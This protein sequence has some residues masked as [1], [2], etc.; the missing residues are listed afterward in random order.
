MNPA[1]RIALVERI[2]RGIA[3]SSLTHDEQAGHRRSAEA[4]IREIEVAKEQLDR[5]G[6]ILVDVA[7][8]DEA[9][10]EP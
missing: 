2:A 9:E 7:Q 3:W 8:G 6:W 10:S 4:V 5:I 1:D